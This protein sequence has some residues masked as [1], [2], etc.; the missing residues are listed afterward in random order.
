MTSSTA[1][2]ERVH[3]HVGPAEQLARA[4]SPAAS[5]PA[6]SAST[7]CARTRRRSCRRAAA[8]GRSRSGARRSAP[9]RSSGARRRTRCGPRAAS[10]L[11]RLRTHRMPSGIEAVDRL[12]E[13]HDLRVAEQRR[14]DPEPLAHP[15]RERAR[16]ACARPSPSPTISISSS[17]RARGDPVRLRER[18]QVVVGGAS[19]VHRLR[20]EQRAALVQRRRVLAVGL[21]VDRARARRRARRARGSAAS[22][23]T[24]RSRSGPRNPVTIPGRTVNVRSCTAVV[25]P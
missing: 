9:S 14:G 18:E 2:L 8:R 6:R 12:V 7:R 22:S 15:E 20:L 3:R 10:P 13:H 5:G 4:G 19:R 17:T 23:S 11:S 24:C 25:E 21:A 1:G 16:R